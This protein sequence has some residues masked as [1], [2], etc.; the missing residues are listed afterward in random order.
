MK[1]RKQYRHIP[2]HNLSSFTQCSFHLLLL[3]PLLFH[4]SCIAMLFSS[5][6]DGNWMKCISTMTI[7]YTMYISPTCVFDASTRVWKYN[8]DLCVS[9][10]IFF[11]RMFLYWFEIPLWSSWHPKQKSSEPKRQR[12]VCIIK[13]IMQKKTATKVQVNT[14][15]ANVWWCEKEKAEG[16]ERECMCGIEKEK[17][18]EEEE[19]ASYECEK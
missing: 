5:A 2:T 8:R 6:V 13:G 12:N 4:W 7:W 17:W 16:R 14:H 15:T 10:S 9:P 1:E 19:L 18:N 3:L 11:H